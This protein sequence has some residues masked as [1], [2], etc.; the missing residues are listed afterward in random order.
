MS[1]SSLPSPYGIGTLGKSAYRFADF[2]KE[3]GQTYWQMLP[4]GP[5]GYGNSPYQSFS[6]FAGNPYFI[7]LDM[8]VCDGLLLQSEIDAVEWGAED[9]YVDYGKIY[10]N[11]FSILK[12]AAERGYK[13]DS[14]KISAFIHENGWVADYALFMACKQHNGMKQ[15][16]EWDDAEL[17]ARDREALAKYT[18]LLRNDIEA[19]IYAQ[20]RFFKQW[21]A[22]RDYAHSLGLKI[23]GDIPVYV[24]LDSADVWTEPWFFK[25][26][27]DFEPFEVAGVPPDY[28]SETGQLWGNPLYDWERMEADGFGWWIRRIGAAGRLYDTLRI[29]HF[30][31]FSEY[32]A[33]PYGEPTAEHGKWRK[34]PG[35]KIVSALSGWFPDIEFVAEDLGTPTDTL[36]QLLRESGW[37]GMKVLGFAFDSKEESSFLPHLYGRNCICYTGTH[38]NPPLMQWYSEAFD[39][40][41]KYAAEYLGTAD[42]PDGF[43]QGVLRAGLGSV[44]DLFVAPMQDYLC[45][46]K[47]A[48]M[49]IPGTTDGNWEW[50]M[51]PEEMSG[52]LAKKLHHATKLY[53]R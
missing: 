28:F 3:A 34:G 48:R 38:D 42:T 46:G 53:G 39:E 41:R 2:L 47:E 20:Y 8:L 10:E 45:L 15:W 29:D 22:L 13:R 6:S 1:V 17:V 25:L 16:T 49:N 26:S 44:A 52:G 19:H 27:E 12:K 51:L 21:D 32:W 35:M 14:E 4:L 33:V 7:D 37:P 23:M 50:R 24:P 11:R 36:K 5:T 43:V 31:G 30:R 40:D 18:D 9:R